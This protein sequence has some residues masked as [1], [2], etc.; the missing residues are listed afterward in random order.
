MLMGIAIVAQVAM[1]PTAVLVGAGDIGRCGS[2]GARSTAILVD[3]VLRADRSPSISEV[4]ITLGDNA[5]PGGSATDFARCFAPSWGDSAL[6]IMQHIRPAPGNHDFLLDTATYYRYFGARAGEPSK[7]YY[8]YDAGSWHVIVLNSAIIVGSHFPDAARSAQEQWLRQDLAASHHLC[9]LVYWHHPRFSSG[10]HGS[11]PRIAPVWRILYDARVDLV[12]NGHDHDY[13]RFLPQ[14]PDAT[15]D[16]AQGITEIVVGTGGG[17]LRGFR[18]SPAPNS[19]FR[20]MGTFGVLKLTLGA[21]EY[22]HA[23]IDAS[24]KVWDS[25]GGKCH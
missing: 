13:E 21:G 9:T 10:W 24:H 7:G 6:V 25:G 15:A 3:S 17:E 12:L 16:S 8:S 11:D 20:L 22:R 18:I 1:G 2:S 23:F 14:T 19:A 4:A 5:Y